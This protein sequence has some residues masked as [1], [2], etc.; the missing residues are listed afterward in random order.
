MTQTDLDREKLEKAKTDRAN[1]LTKIVEY[2]SIYN[3]DKTNDYPFFIYIASIMNYIESHNGGCLTE[4]GLQ[5]LL[6]DIS[7][8]IAKIQTGEPKLPQKD[9]VRFCLNQVNSFAVTVLIKG[10]IEYSKEDLKFFETNDLPEFI[11]TDF[12]EIEEKVNKL[13]PIL[14]QVLDIYTKY[15]DG[16]YIKIFNEE[17]NKGFIKPIFDDA[18]KVKTDLPTGLKEA[19]EMK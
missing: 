16:K 17:K 6:L 19:K 1:F 12:A 13:M 11:K 15:L 7:P 8:F 2:R 18:I 10:M 14:K 3:E 9:L 4:L 5:S